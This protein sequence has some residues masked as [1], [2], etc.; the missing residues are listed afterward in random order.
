[1]RYPRLLMTSVTLLLPGCMG[2]DADSQKPM[3]TAKASPLGGATDEQPGKQQDKGFKSRTIGGLTFDFPVSWEEKTAASTVLLAEYQLPGEA[4]PGRLT[5]SSAGGGMAM[6]LDRW[7]Q[8]FQ[9]GPNDREPQETPIVV[10]G[11]S[12]T[13]IELNGTFIDSFSGGSPK[14][15][16]RLLGVVIPIDGD[17]N[18]FIK[19]TGPKETVQSRNLEF[20]KFTQSARDIRF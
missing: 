2:N 4:G 17:H 19:L 3:V 14:S 9:R 10:A 16:W 11:K 5:F 12:G 20:W 18:F 6:N 1:M 8:Q 7:K 13:M 15:D